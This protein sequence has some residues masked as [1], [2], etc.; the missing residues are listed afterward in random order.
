MKAALLVSSA[1]L[2]IASA[3]ATAQGSITKEE[4]GAL[5]AANGM[6]V[7]SFDKDKP[8]AGTSACTGPCETLWPPY[9]ASATDVPVGPYTIVKRDDGSP[10]WAYKGKPLYFFSKDMKQGERNGDNFK[11]VWHV[12]AP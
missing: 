2:A 3:S 9:K 12:V 1:L 7:Y 4:N 8:N 6:T 11:N 10:Q 5:V